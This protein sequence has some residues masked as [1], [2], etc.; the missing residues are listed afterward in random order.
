LIILGENMKAA[1]NIEFILS[2]VVFL[3]A[4]TFVTFSLINVTLPF[5]HKEAI[6]DEIKSKAFHISELL[7]FKEGNPSD[8]DEN[9]VGGL[10]L[11]TGDSYVLSASKVLALNAT[12]AKSYEKVRQLLSQNQ[13][14]VS[15]DITGLNGNAYCKCGPLVKSVARPEFSVQR[16]AVLDNPSKDIVEISVKVI[17]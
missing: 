7:L 16:I 8:W 13:F 17:G 4:V 6:N 5:F 11:S 1:V 14:D 15:I 2:M 9:N 3:G 12:C 10:G